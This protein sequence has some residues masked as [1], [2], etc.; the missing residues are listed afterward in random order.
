[1]TDLQSRTGREHLETRILIPDDAGLAAA[2][3]AIRRGETVA[4]PTET[5]YGL[6]ADARDDLAVARVFE[7]KRRPSFNPLIVHV[8][9]LDTLSADVEIDARVRALA[10]A[11]W[12]GPLTLV[13]PRRKASRISRLCSAGLESLAVR[14]PRHPVAQRLIAESG[15]PLAAPSA[16]LSGRTSP[17]TAAHVMNMLGG[18]IGIILDGGPTEVGLESSVLDL[19]A[20]Q[21]RLLRQGG[22]AQE[23]LE[24]CLAAAGLPGPSISADASLPARSAAA[25]ADGALPSPGLLSSHYAPRL[26]LRLDVSAVLPGEAL[27]AF[28][29]DVP[30][31]A[32]EVWNLS[33]RG[34]LREAAA[35][36]FAGL[37]ALDRPCFTGIAAM[38]VPEQ[39]LGRAINDRLRRAAAK[40]DGPE[41][42]A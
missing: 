6:G 37:H 2:A 3:A 19:T 42:P 38:A 9:K 7:A 22:L 25:A 36:L 5:V 39:G 27:L 34:D 13:L 10:K 4:F 16:N 24:A 35:R 28:G 30:A 15:C 17:T 14:V 21:P 26:P 11:F 18:R 1:M 40:R 32:A 41:Q 33:P 31:G 20:R 29:P 12:P 23:E 8:T